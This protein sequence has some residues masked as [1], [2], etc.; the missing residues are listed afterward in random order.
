MSGS[1]Q[2][3]SK[4]KKQKKPVKEMTNEEL[5]EYRHQPQNDLSGLVCNACRTGNLS[6][7]AEYLSVSVALHRNI[8]LGLR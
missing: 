6:L 1:G 7:L 3:K 2:T 5:N 4:T 8:F